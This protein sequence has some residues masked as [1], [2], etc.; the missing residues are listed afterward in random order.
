MAEPDKD[1]A[2]RIAD[3]A[4][5]LARNGITKTAVHQFHVDTYRY[6]S[7]AEALAQVARS[8]PEWR[9]KQPRPKSLTG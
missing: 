4:A 3:E 6:S 1:A 7:L 9:A 2:A 8:A 5:L